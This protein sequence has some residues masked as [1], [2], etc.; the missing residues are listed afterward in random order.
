VLNVITLYDTVRVSISGTGLVRPY[1]A[2]FT[3][4]SMGVTEV[5]KTKDS[6]YAN[7]FTNISASTMYITSMHLIG[8]DKTQFKIISQ[9]VQTLLSGASLNIKLNF[10]PTQRGRT[11]TQLYITIKGAAAALVI[12]VYAEGYLPR[13]YIVQLNYEDALTN[14]PVNVSVVCVDSQSD[15]IIE[16]TSNN[17][18]QSSST[19]VYADRIYV[20]S[21]KKKGYHYFSDTINLQHAVVENKII[22]TIKLIPE[23]SVL[24]AAV[25]SGNVFIKSTR[26]PLVTH[27]YFYNTVTKSLV[28]KI[29]S[30]TTGTYNVM[31]P[32]GTYTIV[33]EKEGYL[34]ENVMLEI[35]ADNQNQ[36]RDFE[37]TPIV[38]GETIRLPNVYFARGGVTLLES[39]NE[40]LDQLYTLL[41]DNPTMRIELLGYT[42]NQGDTKL[43]IQLS[44]LR[45]AAIKEYLVAKG[46]VASRIAGKGYGGA[47]PI[48]SNATEETRQLNR[49]VEFKIVSK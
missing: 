40:S 27:I 49:R 4:L 34:N 5:G 8:P 30:D 13:Q 48:A 45:V 41:N 46:V 36:R 15:K 20:F 10:S 24:N 42:D 9:P 43:N 7:V 1:T 21:I 18:G 3:E 2:S 19:N 37:L 32:T 6:L 33:L 26:L 39:S 14:I 31:L 11:S 44:E 12:P 35:I 28:K 22:K 16:S 17:N 38:V 47:K 25:L 23:G 29:Q